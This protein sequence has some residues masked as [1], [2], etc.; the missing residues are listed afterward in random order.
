MRIKNKKKEIIKNLIKNGIDVKVH[1]PVPMHLQPAA[2]NLG[3]R[4]GSFPMTEKIASETISLPVHEFITK[5]NLD[6]IISIFK[7][8]YG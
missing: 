5:K 7:K 1:Y 2:I 4:K 6:K 3:Y 8:V